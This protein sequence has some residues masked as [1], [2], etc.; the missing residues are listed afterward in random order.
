MENQTIS[1]KNYLWVVGA[2]V[3]VLAVVLVLSLNA[4]KNTDVVSQNNKTSEITTSTGTSSNA[5]FAPLT[6]REE[7]MQVTKPVEVI[8]EKGTSTQAK[9]QGSINS[10]KIKAERGTFSPSELV[11]E[12]GQRVQIEFVAV[13]GDYDLDIAPPIGAYVTAKKGQSSTF[14]FDA[15]KNNSGVYTFSCRN[16][17]PEGREMKGTIVVK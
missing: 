10:F 17:C 2:V 13:D 11:F 6:N 14:G 1:K 7:T 4:N 12:K 3:V 8:T 15:G 5:S 16:Y 9:T